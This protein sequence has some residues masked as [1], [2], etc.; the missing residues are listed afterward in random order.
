[1]FR[2]VGERCQQRDLAEKGVC[3][4]E[5]KEEKWE[6]ERKEERNRGKEREKYQG[7]F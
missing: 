4:R 5:R 6:D 1:M 7:G 2:L 3:R